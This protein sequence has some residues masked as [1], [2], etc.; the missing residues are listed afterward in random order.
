MKSVK[1][2][3]KPEDLE[4]VDQIQIVGLKRLTIPHFS[5]TMSKGRFVSRGEVTT[6]DAKGHLRDAME[7]MI[8]G[9]LCTTDPEEI[10]ERVPYLVTKM[11]ERPK[12]KT[13]RGRAKTKASDEAKEG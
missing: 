11:R 8:R 4:L 1:S 6:L 5:T 13:T 10:C 12:P 7:I 2:V 3:V 9:R